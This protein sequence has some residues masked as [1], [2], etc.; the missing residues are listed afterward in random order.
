MKLFPTIL[1]C[2]I[3]WFSLIQALVLGRVRSRYGGIEFSRDSDPAWY[4][5]CVGVLSVFCLS[6]IFLLIVVV[7]GR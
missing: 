5:L 2:V 6:S 4:W 7:L 1:F 3:L